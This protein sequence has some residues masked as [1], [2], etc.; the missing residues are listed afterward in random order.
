ME[1]DDKGS[2]MIRMGVSGWMFLVVPAYPGCPGSKAVKRSLLLLS[3]T[4]AMMVEAEARLIRKLWDWSETE[5]KINKAE[6]V[7]L[8]PR[9]RAVET[10]TGKRNCLGARQLP[11]GLHHSLLPPKWHLGQ[12]C[13]GLVGVHIDTNFVSTGTP[14]RSAKNWPRCCFGGS[15]PKPWNV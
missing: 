8:R 10:K 1:K 9:Q 4:L 3:Q 2:T 15:S 13:A 11:Q 14:M 12:F 5:P 6:A 7:G